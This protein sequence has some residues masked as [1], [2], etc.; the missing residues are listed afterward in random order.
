MEELLDNLEEDCEETFSA[1]SVVQALTASND[2]D[3]LNPDEAK[4]LVPILT[5]FLLSLLSLGFSFSL[6]WYS[7][8]TT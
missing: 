3:F 6:F 7:S 2:R 5:P 8:K 4:A 1:S